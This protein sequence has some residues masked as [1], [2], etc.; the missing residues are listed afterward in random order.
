MLSTEIQRTI[1]IQRKSLADAGLFLF[2]GTAIRIGKGYGRYFSTTTWRVAGVTRKA[3]AARW[4]TSQ[5]MVS[6]AQSSHARRL[7]SRENLLSLK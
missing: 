6:D 1:T 7:S 2:G 5:R 4:P 3:S